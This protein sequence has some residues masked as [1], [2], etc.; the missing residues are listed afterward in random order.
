[1][2]RISWTLLIVTTFG[3]PGKAVAEEQNGMIL[4]PTRK[5]IVGTSEEE[6]RALAKRY[7][8]HPTWLGDE[9][10]RREVE[11]P[12][13]WIDRY[14]VTNA[15]YLAFVQATKHAPPA[16]WKPFGGVFPKDYADH[17]VVGVLAQDAVAYAKWSGK[18]LPRA[19]EWEAAVAGADHSLFAWGDAWPGPLKHVGKEPVFADRPGTRP[20]GGGECGRSAAGVEDFA[21]QVLEWSADA[22]PRTSSP[23]R[24]L[25]GAS[26][27]HQ[28]PLN[29]RVASGYYASE[30]WQSL[31]TGLRCVLDGKE[32]PP[33]VAKAQAKE[34]PPNSTRNKPAT[35]TPPGVSLETIGK[36]GAR[37]ITI[38]VPRFDIEGI[39]LMAPETITWNRASV[40]GWRQKPDL[41]WTERS[42]QRAVYDLTL[43]ELRMHAEFLVHDDYI[44]QRF[45]AK[46][47]GEKP[48]SF[49]TSTCF[50]LQNAL[51]F[52]DPEQLRTY[53]LG[54][55]GQFVSVRK[56]PRG[57][58]FV[59]WINRFRGEE[60]GKN[61]R[62]A[63]L[64][65]VSR[66]RRR[67]IAAGV[68]GPGTDFSDSSNSLFTCLHT[69]STIQVPA[70]QEA[71][72]RE[73]FWFL[74]GTLDDLLRRF[75]KEFPAKSK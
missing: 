23:A 72:S 58:D 7:D 13:F 46:N 34:S 9:L 31:F 24:M 73:I 18:R 32:T 10:P 17:P 37:N 64:A 33:K 48:G 67:V 14:P 66:D 70:G 57:N 1:M 42:P 52:Y 47:L 12:A 11:L 19:E 50:K 61:P 60:L 63:L 25:K 51:M 6:R 74:E 8:C 26:W 36:N 62:W 16:W 20:V 15:Q 39:N 22:R 68:G 43:P 44:E 3:Q 21:G 41:T 4:I 55:D 75:H 40:L 54:A 30:N 45:T 29:F 27:I 56:L 59:R 28:D 71:T 53:A 49:R 5:V 35:K 2:Q 65:V 69:E 38:R